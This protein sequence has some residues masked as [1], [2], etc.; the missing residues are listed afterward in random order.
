V[1]AGQ[2]VGAVIVAYHPHAD[3]LGRLISELDKQ[4]A[5]MVVINN[6][7]ASSLTLQARPRLEVIQTDGNLGVAAAINLGVDRLRSAALEDA[8]LLDQDSAINDDLAT[9]LLE[10]LERERRD[11][12]QVAAIGPS[13]H[14][15]D[16]RQP[17][18][19]IRFRLPLNQ[20]L[21]QEEGCVACDYLIT[22]G[23]LIDLAHWQDIGPMREAWFIDNI[24][25]EWCFRARRKGYEILGCFDAHL[26]HRIGERHRLF[27]LIPYRRHDP[28]RLY[29]MMRN[30]IFLYR[31]GAPFAFIVQDAL[32]AIGKLGLFSLIPPRR[33]HLQKM[34]AG[35]RDGFRTRPLP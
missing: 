31:S 14:D 2:R 6:G 3:R 7:P 4:V 20:R 8:L 18:P 22:S 21:R 1:S 12:R 30:R 28:E 26:D 35:L 25:L 33:R 29:T 5:R 13:I 10:H 15:H 9:T 17:A 19:F 23:C 24:D 32:R 34:L 11:G 16:D 27:G